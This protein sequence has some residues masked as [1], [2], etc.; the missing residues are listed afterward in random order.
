MPAKKKKPSSSDDAD[1]CAHCER[2]E[3]TLSICS[4]CGLVKYC[5]NNCQRAHWKEHKSL[6]GEGTDPVLGTGVIRAD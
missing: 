4:R 3:P 1:A 5:R 6:S 2:L